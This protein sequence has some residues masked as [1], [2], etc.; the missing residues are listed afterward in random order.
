M[1]CFDSNCWKYFKL[2]SLDLRND[3]DLESEMNTSFIIDMNV[4]VRIA[5]NA[6]S[7]Q[8][9]GCVLIFYIEEK[10]KVIISYA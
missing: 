5:S 9:L 1:L 10:K 3:V 8:N 6:F 4:E 7:L 2:V